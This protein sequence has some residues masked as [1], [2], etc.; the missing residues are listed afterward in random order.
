[1]S[2]MEKKKRGFDYDFDDFREFLSMGFR[3]SGTIELL[4]F[5]GPGLLNYL[6]K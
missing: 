4:N 3:R 5:V 2:R 1:M 6:I